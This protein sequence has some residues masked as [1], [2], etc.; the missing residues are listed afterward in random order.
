M[1]VNPA[2]KHNYIRHLLSTIQEDIDKYINE[3][4]IISSMAQY[5]LLSKE[6][7]ESYDV[8]LCHGIGE[9]PACLV[10]ADQEVVNP[11]LKWIQALT[12]GI[13]GYLT[14]S[15]SFVNSDITLTNVKGAFSQ[16]LAEFVALGVL[17]H[18]KHVG[19]FMN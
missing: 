6:K 12:A 15:Q 8:I 18:T 14:S 16:I 7:K 19:R 13:D 9:N 17:Y 10:I 5:D 1:M 3:Y 2:A 4:D 11:K